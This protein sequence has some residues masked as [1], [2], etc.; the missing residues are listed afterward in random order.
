[1]SNEQLKIDIPGINSDA[2]L[3]LYDGNMD[4]FLKSLRLYTSNMPKTLE[5]MREV[6]NETLRDY[7]ISA[8]GAKSISEYIGAYEV[9]DTAKQLEA[10]ALA[11]DLNGILAVNEGFIKYSEDL[12]S[13]IKKWLQA[14]NLSA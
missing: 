14:N 13:N 2:G 4:F 1:M 3:N 7:A 12:I 10:M 11:G 9:R 8:H 5:K 6:S